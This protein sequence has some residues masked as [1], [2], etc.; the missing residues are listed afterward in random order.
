[1]F[2]IYA[3]IQDTC[4]ASMG[5]NFILCRWQ[6]GLMIDAFERN[7]EK[8]KFAN[9]H[10]PIYSVCENFDKNPERFLYALFHW[11]PNFDKYKVM[12]VFEN[13]VHSFKRTKP[14][15]GSNPSEKG[16]VY[17]GDGAYG[18]LIS[19]MCT[20]DASMDIFD[21]FSKSN[22]FWLSEIYQD[23]VVHTAYDSHNKIIDHFTQ[24]VSD[25]RLNGTLE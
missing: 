14:L 10:V 12:T 9:Y 19:E 7:R 3:L 25:Y 21:S 1:M 17:V 15:I 13:H 2:S 4:I 11:V 22:N 20:P 16:T 18:A 5:N 23:R 24:L 8:I 6:K